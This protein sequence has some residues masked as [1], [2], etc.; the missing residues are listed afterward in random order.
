MGSQKGQRPGMN[1]QTP[2]GQSEATPDNGTRQGQMPQDGFPGGERDGG[3]Q[4]G[5]PGGQQGGFGG[6]RQGGFGGGMGG[7]GH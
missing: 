6:E 5:F 3:P 4:G 1:G 2:D 7:R